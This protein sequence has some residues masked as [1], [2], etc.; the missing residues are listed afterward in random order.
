LYN[1]HKKVHAIK[2]QSVAAP[3]GLIASLY[4]PVEGKKH[5]SSMLMMSGLLN[6]LQQHSFNTNG[7]VLCIYGDLAY[8][9]RPQLQCPFK[10]AA[11]TPHHIAWNQ[12]M[13]EVRISVEWLFGDIVNYFKFLDFKK[14]LKVGLSAVGKMYLTCALLQNAHSCVYGST[15]SKY[16]L[17]DPPSLE[18]YF[19]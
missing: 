5:D 18:E 15:T 3:N 8:P 10:G 19:V 13:S 11:L 2:F 14:N 9:L 16:F 7:D 6:Q 17:L 4:G 1:G 12:S